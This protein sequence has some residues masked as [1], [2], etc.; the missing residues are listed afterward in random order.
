MALGSGYK[1]SADTIVTA[2]G[3]AYGLHI[4]KA[5]EKD[6]YT[7]HEV[8]SLLHKDIDVG[9]WTG[10]TCTTGSGRYAAAVY[11]PSLWLNRPGAAERGA[12]AAVVRL[13]DGKATEVAEGV[14]MSYSSPGCGPGDRVLFSSSTASDTS[15]GTTTVISADAATGKVTGNR[16]AKGQITH[17][18]PTASGDYGVLD[19]KLVKLSGSGK[20]VKALAQTALDGPVFALTASQG[21]SLD[22]GTVERGKSVISRW[23]GGKLTRV[24]SAPVGSVHLFPRAGGDMVVGDVKNLDT[25]LA[26]G[27]QARHASRSIEA[28]SREG[29][30]AATSVFSDQMK[31]LTSQIGAPSVQGAGTIRIKATA[32][33]SGSS[34][35]ATVDTGAKPVK[36]PSKPSVDPAAFVASSTSD[37]IDPLTCGEGGPESQCLSGSGVPVYGDILGSDYP[38]IVKRLDPKRQALQA[39][40]DQVEWAV[41]QAVHGD[42]TL[43]RPKDWHSTG[44]DAFSPQGLF[45]QP[46]LTD[47]GTVP[48]QVV[49][50]LLAQESNFKQ[51]SWH[52]VYG[53]SGDPTQADW[54]GNG[55]SIHSYPDSGAADCGYGISQVTTGMNPLKDSEVFNTTEAGAIATDYASN[56]A[57][58]LRILGE[59]WNQLKELGMNVND[60]S[61]KYIENWYMA[62]WGYNSGI[63]TDP[64]NKEGLG[65]LNNPANPNYPPDRDGFLRDTYDDASHPAD[66]PYQERVLGWA[67]HPQLTWQ[68]NASYIQP[69][70]PGAVFTSLNLPSNYFLFC[71]PNVNNCTP[72]ASDPCPSWDAQCRWNQSVSWISGQDS[73]NSSTEALAFGLG[74]SEPPITRQYDYG[75]CI[76]GP[77]S[78]DPSTVVVDDLNQHED[79]YGCGDFEAAESEKFSLQLGDNF[80][81]IRDDGTARATPYIAQI[82]LHQIGVGY[83][84]HSFFTH[85]YATNDFFHRVT[86]RWEVDQKFLPAS[87]DVG[88]RYDVWVH[89]P[90]HG[91]QASVVYQAI[92]GRND[93]SAA[94]LT[95]DLN[96]GAHSN[97]T[98]TWVDL[99]TAQ[100]WKG[101][102]IE[103][104]NEHEAG[105]GDEDVDFDAVAF[106]PYNN[107]KAGLCWKS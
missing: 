84:G 51:A 3:D 98:D 85:N 93:S 101:G 62:L 55:D 29:H 90:S 52:A 44:L 80:T 26:P 22:M 95:C 79:T 28:V 5:D 76:T 104:D 8:A 6:G 21:T 69:N 94:V 82:D 4:M 57:A 43:S 74:S 31:G 47:G 17:L 81:Y 42:L 45:P 83:D 66:W 48:A 30:L 39:P 100:F 96:Q 67:E 73:S 89:L 34:A 46:V 7:F 88:K 105:T 53:I 23:Q 13:S 106:V 2:T 97:G 11:M 60:G 12:F 87:T 1:S 36:D 18:L 20:N 103:A 27:L 91:A 56:I 58:G 19:G 24:G 77:T 49:L 78:D 33:D 68:G 38:C 59:K 86:A 50:G 71:D 64:N 16:K 70:F 107:A 61:S 10:Y 63:Y 14:Q 65:F 75:P 72:N 15:S 92:P 102:R 54:F 25:S 9:P 35:S 40:A 32:L 41:D 37:D 99:G